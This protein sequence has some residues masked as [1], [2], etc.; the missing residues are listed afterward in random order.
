MADLIY[1]FYYTQDYL[2]VIC[3]HN[4]IC[5]VIPKDI[6]IIMIECENY[7]SNHEKDLSS[8]SDMIKNVTNIVNFYVIIL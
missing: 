1:I 7:R 8:G 2:P 6:T 3:K 5:H 4:I